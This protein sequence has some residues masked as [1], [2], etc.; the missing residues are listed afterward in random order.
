MRARR[1]DANLTAIV[2]AYRA[3]GCTVWIC[4][5]NVDCIVGYSGISELVEVKDGSKPP[6]A[7]VLTPAQ[8]AFRRVW[9]GGIRLVKSLDEV[10]AHV[11][12]IRRKHKILSDRQDVL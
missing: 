5:S 7:R 1:V 9:T 10:A 3:L 11:A 12:D 4:N 8:V 6:S 2:S